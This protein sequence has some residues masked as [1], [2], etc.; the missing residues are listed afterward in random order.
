MKEKLESVIK[1]YSE[2]DVHVNN[3][4]DKLLDKEIIED[5]EDV[6]DSWSDEGKYSYGDIVY[7][8]KMDGQ[9]YYVT[10]TQSR[11]GSYYSDY[12]YNEPDLID[13]LTE[14]EYNVPDDVITVQYK[15]KFL[16]IRE[17]KSFVINETVY[18]SLEEAIASI[19]DE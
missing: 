14:E 18:P 1:E 13:I 17:D 15:D 7:K 19:T 8:V 5:Y 3:L 6:E 11:T 4:F 9:F 16:T 2:D 12:Y 10:M